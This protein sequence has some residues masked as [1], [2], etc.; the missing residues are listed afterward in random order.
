MSACEFYGLNRLTER[1]SLT[2]NFHEKCAR[3]PEYVRGLPERLVGV[4]PAHW[5]ESK[6][7]SGH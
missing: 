3:S 1:I 7:L 4:S 5:P 2:R 6:L